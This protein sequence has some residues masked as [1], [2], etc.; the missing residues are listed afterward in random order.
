MHHAPFILTLTIRQTTP[1]LNHSLHQHS[2]TGQRVPTKPRHLLLL[3]APATI[4]HASASTSSYKVSSFILHAGFLVYSASLIPSI[5]SF[6][7]QMVALNFERILMMLKDG[8][9]I[10]RDTLHS[11]DGTNLGDIRVCPLL[12][13]LCIQVHLPRCHVHPPLQGHI[14]V[15]AIQ[16][17]P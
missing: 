1:T 3:H 16:H 6:S 4:K 11:Q 8:D 12:R 17:T 14:H 15:P 7:F 5:N 9:T 2:P 10:P 13:T